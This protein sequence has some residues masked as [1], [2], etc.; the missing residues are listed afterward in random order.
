LTT[1]RL[2]E[3]KEK[4]DNA[5]TQQAEVKGQIHSVEEQMSAKFKVKTAED[6]S[7]ELKKRTDELDQMEK[8]FEAGEEE[9]ENAYAWNE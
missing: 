6:A 5:K 7:K 2:L 1:Q 8:G 4:I 9:L 3:I